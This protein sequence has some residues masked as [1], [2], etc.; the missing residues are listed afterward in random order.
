MHKLIL[1][2]GTNLGRRIANISTAI[3]QIETLLGKVLKKS[4]VYETAAWGNTEQPDFLNQVIQVET[5]KN[6]TECLEILL[7]IEAGMGRIRNLKWEPRIIDIDILFYDSEII[8]LDHLKI[9]HPELH[10][11]KFVLIPLAEIL[12][13]F[14]HPQSLKT[15]NEML[16][17]VS[18]PLQCHVYSESV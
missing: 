5:G 7:Q 9:P 4:S 17:E 11:R 18:D 12:P 13:E 10:R 1:L 6:P 8:N 15:A 14:V 16:A 2:L 3:H